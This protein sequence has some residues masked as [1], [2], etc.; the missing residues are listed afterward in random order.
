MLSLLQATP[1]GIETVIGLMFIAFLFVGLAKWA[2]NH[3]KMQYCGNCGQNVTTVK[4]W[5]WPIFG[6][7]LFVGV[8]LGGVMYALYYT[9]AKNPMCPICNGT[10]LGPP[11]QGQ[12]QHPQES[13]QLQQDQ[14]Q[15]QRGN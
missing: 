13:Q 9:W 10:Y 7:L 15:K 4:E 1:R 12:H 11:Q 2:S 3:G 5:S 6:V 8:G 14:H